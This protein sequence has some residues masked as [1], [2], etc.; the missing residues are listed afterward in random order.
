MTPRR[1]S[2]PNGPYNVHATCYIGPP[3]WISYLDPIGEIGTANDWEDACTR[4]GTIRFTKR[5]VYVGDGLPGP[6]GQEDDYLF[7]TERM[8]SHR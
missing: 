1:N 3:G 6:D 7:P 4:F 8:T 5:G 2:K